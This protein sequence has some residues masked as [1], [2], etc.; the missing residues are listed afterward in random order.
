[1]EDAAGDVNEGDDQ[2]Q[3]ERVDDVVGQLRSDQVEPERKRRREAEDGRGAE[4]R[5]D[6]DE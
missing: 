3:F 6:A 2:E 4:Q 5:V 1:V